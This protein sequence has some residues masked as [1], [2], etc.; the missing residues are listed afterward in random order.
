MEEGLAIETSFL[1]L[2]KDVRLQ[3]RLCVS[4]W[5]WDCS[6]DNFYGDSRSGAGKM[7]NIV[8]DEYF[9][10]IKNHEGMMILFQVVDPL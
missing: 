4:C 3:G 8:R 1:I 6:F 2:W 5:K 10:A 7:I 9:E